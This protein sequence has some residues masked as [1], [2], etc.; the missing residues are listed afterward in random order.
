MLIYSKLKRLQMVPLD[1]LEF[2]CFLVIKAEILKLRKVPSYLMIW[3][4]TGNQ[5]NSKIYYEYYH[6]SLLA[7]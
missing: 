6:D 4:N 3:K 5:I 2:I 1:V 7:L